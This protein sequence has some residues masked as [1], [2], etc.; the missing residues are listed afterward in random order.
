MPSVEAYSGSSSPTMRFDHSN[1]RP[2]SSWGTPMMS[3]MACRGSS[4]A[5]SVTKSQLP[6]SMTS[7]MI[8]VARRAR[9]CS[10][11]FIVRGVKPL[12]TRRR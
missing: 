8:V 9:D 12:L 11:A 7:S 1:K 3:A 10:M 4:A 5:T 2:R 6:F